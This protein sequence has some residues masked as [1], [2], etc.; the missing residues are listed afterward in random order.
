MQNDMQESQRLSYV[1]AFVLFFATY[2]TQML[3]VGN[4]YLHEWLN[5]MVNLGTYSIYME[6]LGY[7]LYHY[8]T[9]IRAIGMSFRVFCGYLFALFLSGA[10]PPHF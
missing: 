9:N 8:A 5:L 3:H 2:N 7:I 4:I 6:H 1:V 10:K